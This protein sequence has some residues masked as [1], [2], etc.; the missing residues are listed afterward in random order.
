MSNLFSINSPIVSATLVL[1]IHLVHRDLVHRTVQ[2]VE[3]MA[4]EESM[5]VHSTTASGRCA[6]GAKRRR[7]HRTARVTLRVWRKPDLPS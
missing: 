3:T 5:T 1:L 2:V 4:S 7:R 6:N